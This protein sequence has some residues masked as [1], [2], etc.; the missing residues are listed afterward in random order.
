MASRLT[1]VTGRPSRARWW[2]LLAA[3]ATALAAITVACGGEEIVE[4]VVVQT[5]IVEKQVPGEKVVETVIVEKQVAGEKVVETVIVEKVVT[6][7]VVETVVVE[8]L[9]T[10]KVVETVII[11]KE[12]VVLK[13]GIPKEVIVTATPSRAAEGPTLPSGSLVIAAGGVGGVMSGLPSDC[14][15]C[16]VLDVAGIT[17]MVLDTVR[18]ADGGL[19]HVPHL[20][21]SWVISSDFSYTDF[22]INSG[23]PFQRGWGVMTA[24]DVAWSYNMSNPAVTPESIHD[25]GG[26]LKTFLAPR[27]VE[28]VG[29]FTVRFFWKDYSVATSLAKTVSPLFQG[30]PVFSKKVFDDQ[31]AEWMRDNPIG[32]GPFTLEDWTVDDRLVA[33][34]VPN[35]W[36]NTSNVARVTYLSVPE[37]ATRRAMLETGEADITSVNLTD[38]PALLGPGSK[39]KAA[40]EG[41]TDGLDIVTG[42]NYWEANHPTSGVALDRPDYS[43]LPWV[44]DPND[45]TSMENARKVR[46][47]LSL[48]VDRDAINEGLFDGL[49]RA[50]YIGG[51]VDSDPVFQAGVDKWRM[52]YD[53][54]RARQMLAE[55]GY[56]DGFKVGFYAGGTKDSLAGDLLVQAIAAGWKKD[57]GVDTNIILQPYQSYRPIWINRDDHAFSFRG[58]G[59]KEPATWSNEWYASSS[60][61]NDDGSRGGGF[62]SGFEFPIASEVLKRKSEAKTYDELVT[63]TTDWIDFLWEQQ[64]WIGVIELPN[65]AIYNSERICEWN[66]HPLTNTGLSSGRN[67]DTVVLCK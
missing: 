10:E 20:A 36:F 26:E 53:P 30:I 15:N 18:G 25:Q 38:W 14:P 39:F 48:A 59:T 22:T 56:P 31:G 47:A 27:E 11:E 16:G 49:G 23:V 41:K 21:K 6:E 43:D 3:L 50:S 40:P 67:L 42:G 58:G 7:K 51:I 66:L 52:P 64:V 34:A 55:A 4:K 65:K 12:I 29:P 35:H 19:E 63:I 2:A 37:N 9:V 8:K 33:N 61:S 62:N 44:G 32:T 45:P 5:V 28:V 13:E 57:L 54:Q 46:W 17:D 1:S 60:N 24:E